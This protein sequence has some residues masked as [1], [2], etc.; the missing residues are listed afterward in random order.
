MKETKFLFYDSQQQYAGERYRFA[1]FASFSEQA[2][3][4]RIHDEPPHRYR[5]AFQRDR[6][7]IIHSRAFRRLKH[8]RQVFVTNVGDH[9][10]T[11]LTHTM[12]VSQLA[13]TIARALG[14]N[15]DLTEAIA[16]G[17][18]LGHAPFGHLGEVLLNEILQGK[19]R[20][21][22]GFPNKNLGGFKHNYQSLRVLDLL[23]SK[24]AFPGLN[25][26]A[27]VREGILKHT[28]MKKKYISYPD[29]QF[30]GL[31]IEFGY[32]QTLEGQVVEMADEIAQRTHDLEDG[33][34]AHL[35]DVADIR[36]LE[37]VLLVENKLGLKAIAENG[38]EL[39]QNRIINGLIDFLVT[40]LLESTL[41]NLEAYA[42]TQQ[43]WQQINRMLVSFSKP[44]DVLQRQLNKF[45][46][47][48]IIEVPEVSDLD[49]IFRN[50]LLGLYS[51]FIHFPE[52]LTEHHIGNYKNSN[53]QVI[54]PRTICDH[55][56]GMTDHF[57]LTEYQ[58]LSRMD[59]I[60]EAFDFDVQEIVW[61]Q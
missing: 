27:P 59:L 39:Y 45:I 31:N 44:V 46:F 48:H 2:D 3:R 57:A 49:D 38:N 47:K 53:E 13:R 43:D 24:Y 40:D 61:M 30:Q 16:V 15:E 20:A 17:H 12:E 10:R 28:Q 4:T 26:T 36:Q 55:I 14:L 23:E 50:V 8:K 52:M 56:A 5:T 42:E 29:F 33:I 1:P 7:R 35:V 37:I 32:A 21:R 11:R 9:Y 6:D 41:K 34:R 18:D 51:A 19:H 22:A 54:S 25:L 58:R 60:K